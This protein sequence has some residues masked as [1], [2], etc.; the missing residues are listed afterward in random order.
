MINFDQMID[1]YLSRESKPKTEG[2]YYPSE[3]GTCIRKIWYSY[4]YPQE[5]KADLLKIFHVGNMMH[6]FVAEVLKSEKNPD[7][8]LLRSEM[9]LRLEIEDLVISGRVDD[10]L[11]LKADGKNLLVEVKSAKTISFQ[12]KPSRHHVMQ[13]QLYMHATGV[14]NGIILYL[15][16]TT[17]KSRVFTIQYNEAMVNSILS[18][19]K[20]LHKLLKCNELPI[21]EAKSDSDT[22]WMCGFCEYRGK[23]DKNEG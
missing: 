22:R 19:F 13:L 8:E 11:L 5:V 20:S 7:V 9:P 14:H 21:A 6:D 1:R 23:C 12:V 10:L 18:R 15:D 17:L 4:K 2:R 16:K 3:I